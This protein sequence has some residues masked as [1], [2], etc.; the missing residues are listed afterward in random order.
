MYEPGGF[1][2]ELEAQGVVFRKITGDIKLFNELN[3]VR[4]LKEYGLPDLTDRLHTIEDLRFFEDGKLGYYPKDKTKVV[5]GTDSGGSLCLDRDTG[6]MYSLSDYH[7]PVMFVN[8]S[9]EDFLKCLYIYKI[10]FD[11]HAKDITEDDEI[12]LFYYF[13]SEF[14]KIDKRILSDPENWWS[15]MIETLSYGE[16]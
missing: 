11:D 2:K 3:T 9:F 8:S 10:K 16:L 4:F 6:V 13:T 15:Q 7:Y 1:V 5:I 12:S 14:N